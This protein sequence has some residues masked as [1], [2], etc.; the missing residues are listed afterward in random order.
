VFPSPEMTSRAA[1]FFK[2]VHAVFAVA[3]TILLSIILVQPELAVRSL[4]S[5]LI[6]AFI[7]VLVLELSIRGKTMLA[8]SLF[9]AG[10]VILITGNA[11]RAGGIRS[12]GLMALLVFVLMAG[13]LLG[14]RAAIITAVSCSSLGLVLVGLEKSGM[15]PVQSVFYSPFN[16][17]LLSSV[18]M[19]LAILLSE[20]AA[21]T[22]TGALKRAEAELIERR[23]TEAQ[24]AV[25]VAD[26]KERVKELKLLHEAAELLQ[27]DRPFS[28]A[29]LEELVAKIP[30]A[31]RYP[32][33]CAACVIYRDMVIPTSNWQETSW[34]LVAPFAT[35]AG[36]GSIKVAYL[37]DYPDAAAGPFLKEERQLLDSLAEMLAA[38]LAHH[39]AEEKRQKAEGQL[40]Q[41]QK[42]E[43]IGTL[44][45][46]IAH[47]FNNILGAILGYAELARMEAENNPKV[48]ESIEE[49]L[50]GG[51][52]AT[53]LVRQILAFSRQQEQQL[54]PVQ[55]RHIVSEAFKL[56]RATISKTIEFKVAV[57]KE[58]P[59]VLAD[60]TQIHQVVM[61]LGTNA[62]HAMKD[63]PGRL[64]VRL[65]AFS[66]DAT[67]SETKIALL[68][69]LYVRLT[70]SDNGTGMSPETVSR[71][72]EPFF[73][74]KA[75]GEGTGLG[76]SVVHGI[77]QNHKG[78]ITVY[79]EL[80]HG[81]SFQVYLPALVSG[82]N[83]A[84][85]QDTSVPRGNGERILLVDDEEIL[86]ELGRKLL[87]RMGYSPTVFTNPLE[88]LNFLREQPAN[89]DLLITDF[90]MSGMTGMDLARQAAAIRP[91]LPIVL[92][93][94]FLANLTSERVKEAGVSEI[95]LKPLTSQTLGVA[96]H[97]IFSSSKES[98]HG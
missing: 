70:V 16:L 15:L 18:Y 81:T 76:L 38:Y 67:L 58:V 35:A 62:C 4:C 92:V 53:D 73:T 42:L 96:L 9:V 19:C 60:A 44:A 12:P 98:A 28:R 66:L 69:G 26:L 57:E 46:G 77:I 32:E 41:T 13:I 88:G 54:K 11:I 64:E 24:Q 10:L 94:G 45:G 78:A 84:I 22:V 25:L 49:V 89:C 86:A 8:G 51:R 33:N 83:L 30:E 1:V 95:L 74:T 48:I 34:T 23:K 43:A 50:R 39:V 29:V 80:G 7:V 14:K 63:R 27:F 91:D 52:R 6:V 56:L 90:T 93:S 47:D 72:F 59:P 20:L 55:L 31:W 40:R 5:L 71:I 97:R 3:T 36:E 2:V 85:E 87:E 65:E 68:P 82:E 79:S 21:D 75:P 61:N 17:W 37:R